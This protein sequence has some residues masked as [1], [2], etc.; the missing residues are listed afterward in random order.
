[1]KTVT[2][3]DAPLPADSADTPTERP[4][5]DISSAPVSAIAPSPTNP[6]KNSPKHE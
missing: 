5:R 6:R 2:A 3:Q 4:A 1:M